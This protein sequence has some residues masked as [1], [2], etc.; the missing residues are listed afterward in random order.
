MASEK[1]MLFEDT[2]AAMAAAAL[3][4]GILAVG[5]NSSLSSGDD[6]KCKM[7]GSNQ[8]LASTKVTASGTKTGEDWCNDLDSTKGESHRCLFTINATA[9]DQ[10]KLNCTSALTGGTATNVDVI[11][12]RDDQYPNPDAPTCKGKNLACNLNN[13]GGGLFSSSQS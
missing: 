10:V 11:C 1:F 3:V 13:G 6:E 12:Q 2:T 4:L 7:C 5:H 9:T 8:Q